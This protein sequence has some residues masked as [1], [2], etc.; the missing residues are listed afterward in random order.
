VEDSL[1]EPFDGLNDVVRSKYMARYFAERVLAPR[2]PALLP[3][4]EE[5]IAACVVDGKGDQGVDFICR[6]GDVV[7]ILQAKYSGGGKKGR[8]ATARGPA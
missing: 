3:S 1:Q 2:N 7:L 5:D 4:A 6:E 8:E